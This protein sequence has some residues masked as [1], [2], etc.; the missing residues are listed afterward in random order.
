M[1]TLN[2]NEAKVMITWAGKSP[3]WPAQVIMTLASLK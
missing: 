3:V 2:F 1:D